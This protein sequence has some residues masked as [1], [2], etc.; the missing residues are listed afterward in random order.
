MAAA[1]KHLVSQAGKRALGDIWLFAPVGSTEQFGS[2]A[3]VG[4]FFAVLLIVVGLILA[5]ACAN[6]AGLVAGAGHRARREMAVRV[7][8]GASRRRLVQQL[9]TE[10]SGSRAWN[11]RG[12]AADGRAHQPHSQVPLPLP[13]PLEIAPRARRPALSYS[14]AL[15]LVA[16]LLVRWR[17]RCRRR[18][19]R[20]FP[21]SSS[22]TPHVAGR[23]W[24]MR[25]VLVVGQ[26]SVALLLLV[27]ALL[28]VRNLSRAQTLDPG[29]DTC[30]YPG[31]ADWLRAEQ[32]HACYRHGLAGGA[33][34]RRAWYARRREASYAFGAP[35]TLRSGMTT[36]S[37]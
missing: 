6:V 37:S 1:G 23:R 12:I 28:F 5:I 32:V 25:N 2:L 22:R 20:R 24:S 35:L 8:L 19:V 16:T 15:V 11:G 36:G 4:A 29:F 7:A 13:L 14:F 34:E 18:G 9:L 21:R 27:T 33:V 3:T 17:R 26:V 31:R 10:G 30:A